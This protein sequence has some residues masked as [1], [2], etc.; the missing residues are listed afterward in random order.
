MIDYEDGSTLAMMPSL[1]W[2][3]LG[4]HPDGVRVFVQTDHRTIRRIDLTSG[5]EVFSTIAHEGAITSLKV[6]AQA[7]AFASVSYDRTVRWWNLQTGVLDAEFS[8]DAPLSHCDVSDDGS[9]VVASGSM[10]AVHI[11]TPVLTRQ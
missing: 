4:V 9:I 11:L 10:G 2:S 7:N 5:D 8:T 6:A 1:G 3:L